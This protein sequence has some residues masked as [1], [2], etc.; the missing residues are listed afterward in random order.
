[1]L[2]LPQKLPQGGKHASTQAHRDRPID[3][4]TIIK[5]SSPRSER[6][7]HWVQRHQNGIRMRLINRIS[8]YPARP[9]L[10]HSWQVFNQMAREEKGPR[11]GRPR[12]PQRPWQ[13]RQ[14]WQPLRVRAHGGQHRVGPLL[15]PAGSGGQSDLRP[16]RGPACSGAWTLFLGQRWLLNRSKRGTV[17]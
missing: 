12:Q 13:P 11:P 5:H 4:Q 6:D 15:H 7:A 1:M 17:R 14:P 8:R 16:A 3:R 2:T 9:D 10:S